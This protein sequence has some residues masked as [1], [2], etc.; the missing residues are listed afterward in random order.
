MHQQQI[1]KLQR[2]LLTMDSEVD[3]G[4]VTQKILAEKETTIQLL[5]KILKIPVTQLIQA[6][7]L[8]ELEKEKE[9]LHRELNDYKA[10]S[11]KLIGEKNQCEKEKRF[12][13]YKNRCFK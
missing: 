12:P 9:F 5:K 7:E 1:K 11:L 8:T 3:E 2:Y 10:K 4:K 13:Y 6:S